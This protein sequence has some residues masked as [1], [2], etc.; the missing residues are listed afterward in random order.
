MRVDLSE[1]EETV[2]RLNRVTEDMGESVSK[3]RYNTYLP[4]GALGAHFT[5][6]HELAAAHD[7]MKN[8][9]EGITRVIHEVIDEFGRNTKKAHGNYQNA[10][11]D[12]N[13]AMNGDH[14]PGSG[15]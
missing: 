5:E 9:I 12:V 10:E 14:T 11:H 8:H 15:S 4:K 7:V 13:Q 6:A 2:R 3:A 1:L